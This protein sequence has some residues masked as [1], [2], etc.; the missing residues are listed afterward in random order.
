[1]EAK[2]GRLPAR[3][4]Q[5]AMRLVQ[6]GTFARSV[7]ILMSGAVAAQGIAVL[8]M[9]V[10]TRLYGP[11][12]FGLLASYVA[13]LTILLSVS[14]LSLNLAITLPESDD[15][16]MHLVVL[17][18]AI[19]LAVVLVLA[20]MIAVDG[21]GVA[22]LVRQPGLEPYL[23]LL[24]VGL[25]ASALYAVLQSWA[26]RKKR[27]ALVAQTRMTRAVA[28][29]GTQI[30]MGIVHS[31]PLGLLLGHAIYSGFG[32]GGLFLSL[33][34]NDRPLMRGVSLRGL[35]QSLRTYRKFPLVTTPAN[36]CNLVG[37]QLPIL[38]IAAFVAP[39]EVGQV[40]I[41]LQ[42]LGL[43]MQLLGSAV[44]QV[45]LAEAPRRAREGDL[46][47]FTMKS[48]W[49][50]FITGAPI[51][52]LIAILA[53]LTFPL[54][55]GDEWGRSGVLISW[56][57]PWFLLQ[58]IASPISNLLYVTSRQGLALG[59]QVFGAALRAGVVALFIHGAT[60]WTSEAYAVSGAAFY[61]IYIAVLVLVA[62]VEGN[63]RARAVNIDYG[64]G[65]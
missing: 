63:K 6:K 65:L 57:A 59:L 4:R 15:E 34:K 47:R 19:G 35:G 24:P 48:M 10:L 42:V 52:L 41:A 45:Y 7:A 37:I 38:L 32:V 54:L 11:T 49:S 22:A 31:T 53:P 39:A 17:A 44:T 26:A 51:L 43:P 61:G 25:G 27:F 20:V 3:I 56:M 21:P 46:Q 60:A 30:G 2:G 33:W 16:A 28:G 14:T 13:I 23:W 50:L 5:S 8:A 1:M 40:M 36:L 12:E 29:F 18:S 58:F 55:L 64:P 62:R 9:P